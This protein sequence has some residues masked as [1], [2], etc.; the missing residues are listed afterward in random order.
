M[1]QRG[2]RLEGLDRSRRRPW[3]AVGNALLLVAL[4]II[5]GGVTSSGRHSDAPVSGGRPQLI[6]DGS[7]A[8]DFETLALET[9]DQFLKAFEARSD[10]FGDVH[11]KAARDLHSRAGYDPD[12]A[13]VTV[14]VPGTRAMLQSALVHEWA[15]HVE[16]QCAAHEEL[17]PA[18]LA[19]Q[20]VAPGTPWRP[21]AVPVN[22]PASAW[23]DIP[24]EQYAEATI[25]LVLG[26]RQIPTK[27][28]VR[29]EAVR[30]IAEWAA[31]DRP[32]ERSVEA[33]GD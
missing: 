18:F 19:A 30:V 6:V 5:A 12:T 25:V 10:C 32:A 14:R 13:T 24:S 20:G 27:V 3:S 26:G 8:A 21:D 22:T 2:T 1:N 11:L 29:D 16:F 17:R 7:V 31:G 33:R 28:R 4:A 23:A 9:W 15:H